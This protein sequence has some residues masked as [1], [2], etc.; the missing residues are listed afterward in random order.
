MVCRFAALPLL[1]LATLGCVT[2]QADADVLHG[3]LP[4]DAVAVLDVAD[5]KQALAELRRAI[6]AVP[7]EL[8]L[9]VRLYLSAG[10]VALWAGAQ[11]N[12]EAWA[13]RVARGGAAVA[14]V[15]TASGVRAVAV[16]RPGDRESAQ[17]W[18][19]RHAER[20]A[21]VAV[22][23]VLVVAA[24]EALAERAATQSFA[25]RWA[26]VDFGAPAAVRA[27]V[28]LAAVRVL[29]GAGAARFDALDGVGRFV[30]GP[31]VHALEHGA[32]LRLAAT[33]GDRLTVTASVDASVRGTPFGALLADAAAG[34]A[35]SLGD[36]G[37]ASLRLD[38]SVLT[39]LRDPERFLA[40]ESV[41]AARGFLSIADALDGAR[42]SFL[43]DLLGGLGEPFELYVLPVAATD[44][45][46]APP[47]Q[48]PGFAVAAPL[49]KP[50]T[51]PIL[52]RAAQAILLIA[53]GERAQQ[54]KLPFTARMQHS[55]HGRGFVAEAPAWRG[56]GAPP[57]EQG[58]SPTLW[59]ENGMV[60]L[61]ST[62]A[63]ADATIARVRADAPARAGDQ[64]VLRGPAIAQW[65]AANRR[66]FELA[67][68]LDEGEDRAAASLFV[69]TAV[70]ITAAVR[71][72][73]LR[74]RCDE[75]AT[76]VE[77]TME[78]AR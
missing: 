61:A 69:D 28:D 20:A 57:I 10:L 66:P 2:A 3:M 47:L 24:D 12:P 71:E 13:E 59:C 68:M 34:P 65:L 7:D 48:L 23:D 58:L 6:G 35:V 42:T 27:V 45:G 40:P 29:A 67:R 11:G 44:D 22:G 31:V 16:L 72:L 46:P 38:R 4:D 70:A 76:R 15:P 60:V 19:H 75:K 17:A 8:P 41:Q 36:D 51:E 30:L 18:L 21:V 32:W 77:L 74:A 14:W 25:S 56:P 55:E 49:R 50:A 63:A 73:A 5:P 64:L 1:L 26:K 33:G 78:R 52:L 39:L 9:A 62:R 43:D 54:Y 53:N 37:L